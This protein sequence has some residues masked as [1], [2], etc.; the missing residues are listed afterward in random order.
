MRIG[1]FIQIMFW[2]EL[3]H[4]LCKLTWHAHLMMK[5]IIHPHDVL[6][7]NNGIWMLSLISLT[8]VAL[9]CRT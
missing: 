7:L 9:Y 4:E 3:C 2:L 6:K 5:V 1:H 8:C